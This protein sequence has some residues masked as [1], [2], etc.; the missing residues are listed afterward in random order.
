[1]TDRERTD[2][3]TAQASDE[4]ALL[5]DLNAI[6]RRLLNG[7]L[8]AAAAL[9]LPAVISGSLTAIRDGQLARILVFAVAYLFILIITFGRNRLPY[10]LRAISLLTIALALGLDSLRSTGLGGSGRVFFLAFAVIA[11]FLFGLRGGLITL[12]L[13]L[14]ATVVVAWGMS[15]GWLPITQEVMA[16]TDPSSWL[17]GGVVYTLLATMLVVSL[18][19]LLRGLANAIGQQ[20]E[21]LDRLGAQQGQLEERVAER[22]RELRRQSLQLE[23]TAE[24]ARLTAETDDLDE[25]MAR[26]IELVRARFGFYHASIFLVDE[27]T[28][29]AEVAA[30][31]GEAGQ[32][33]LTRRHR[34]AI[35]SASIIGWV[36]ANRLPRV[37]PDVEEDPFHFRNP[38]LPDTK[39]E[40][41]VPLMLGQRLIGALD[42]QSR[43]LD[44]F[45]E[46]NIRAIEAI[47]SELAFAIDNSRLT[48]ERRRQ[49]QRLESEVQDRIRE[50]WLEYAR[51][52]T[53][54]II[55]VGT[56]DA[57]QSE[58]AFQHMDE[59]T[60]RG[61]TSVSADGM[62]VVVPVRVRGET[63]AAIAARKS[64]PGDR[65]NEDD[66]ALIESVAGQAALALET[67]RQYGEEQRRV[68]E[69]EVVN[70]VSQ[71]A[72]QLLRLETLLRMVGRQVHGVLRQTDV[73]IGLYDEA[74]NQLTFPYV[75]LGGEESERPPIS[76]TDGLESVVIRTRQPLL[77]AESVGQQ[78]A[79]LGI[80]LP[81]EPPKA[82]L[83]VP[84]LVGDQLLGVIVAQD[85]QRER[86]FTEDDLGLLS[87]VAGQMAT[88]IQNT[89]LLEQVQ[90][91]ARRE[92]LIHEISSKVRQSP[93]IETV[94]ETTAREVGRALNVSRT[95]VRL[96][97]PLDEEDEAEGADQVDG[98]AAEAVIQ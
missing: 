59:V 2:Q 65:W 31:T 95:T 80:R 20:R 35:G 51:A 26:A 34:L 70:R 41:A 55:H 17:T 46:T 47:A 71:A 88:A 28:S 15:A 10:S 16:S 23:A 68:A 18:G 81:G 9:G 24:I 75:L 27:T 98:G 96:G 48:E 78:A 84:M 3:G 90:R 54:S 62:E 38:A 22:T 74:Q 49:L 25:L 44:A 97:T 19:I 87:T 83:G 77:L 91:S 66:I 76:A 72:S 37:S 86:R 69:L 12:A 39:S 13:T 92:R 73:S 14:V 82:W 52:S 60:R 30:S 1:M 64:E 67:A 6:Q 40:M 42:V 89:R 58:G 56:G 61:E 29:W 79:E 33:L 53:P 4:P 85:H 50:S 32:L 36:T 5:L 93:D 11:T 57:S 63:I 94:L 43:E 45:D 8:Y 7:M 21:L